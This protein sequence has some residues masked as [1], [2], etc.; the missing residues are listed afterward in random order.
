MAHSTRF[1]HS[2]RERCFGKRSQSVLPSILTLVFSCLLAVDVVACSTCA[3]RGTIENRETCRECNGRGKKSNPKT[4]R[5]P[6]CD[7]TGKKSYSKSESGRWQGTFCRGCGGTG[8]RRDTLFVACE[9]CGGTGVKVTRVLCPTCK[10]A[11]VVKRADAMLAGRDGAGGVSATDTVAVGACTQCDDKGKSSRRIVCGICERGWNH[12][13][14]DSGAFVCRKCGAVC[15]SRF[16]ACKCGTPDCPH[17]KGE[18]EKTVSGV[19]PLCNGD[20]IITPLERSKAQKEKEERKG[21]Q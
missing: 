2:V 5:C 1:Y 6:I 4:D 19:C 8:M 12:Q 17:C 10:G 14:N 13:K 9:T 16:I 11:S 21:K 15:E 18:Y 20:K 3:D 7:G